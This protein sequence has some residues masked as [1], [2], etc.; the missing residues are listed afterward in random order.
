MALANKTVNYTPFNKTSWGFN[1][2]DLSGTHSGLT[3]VKVV[4]TV[5]S[6]TNQWDNTGHISTPTSGS[7]VASYNKDKFEWSCSGPLAD[8]DAVLVALDLFPADF[9]AIRSWTNL[10]IKPNETDGDF[11]Y[12]GGYN[13][14][15]EQDAPIP[16]TIFDLK[17]YD[18]DNLSAGVVTGG[19]YEITFDAIHPTFG[20]QRPYWSTEPS[21]EDASS[22][23]FSLSTGG[24]LDLGEISQLN[25][26]TNVSDDDPLTLTCEFRSFGV[27]SPPYSGG[28]YGTLTTTSDGTTNKIFIGNKK[29]GAEDTTNR[30]NFTGTRAEVQ[31]YLDNV[32]Y[33]RGVGATPSFTP[34]TF[35]PNYDAFDM[36]FKLSNGVVA[37]EYTKHIH[38]SDAVIGATTI[39]GLSYTEDTVAD[40]D[41]NVATSD[42]S[43][44]VTTYTATITLDTVGIGGVDTFGTSSSFNAS[45]YGNDFTEDFNTSTG[46]LTI[47]HT[48]TSGDTILLLALRNLEFTPDAD[49]NSSFNM[50]FQLIY[51]GLVNGSTYTSTQ[52]TVAVS[53]TPV[54][55]ID[56]PTTSHTFA[57]DTRYNFDSGGAG[58]YPQISHPV[59]ENFTVTFTHAA[60]TGSAPIWRGGSVPST[61]SNTSTTFTMSGT[62]NEVN[63]GFQNLYYSPATDSTTGET[64]TFTVDRTSGDLTHETQST[65]SFVMTATEVA[66][67]T[68]SQ[69]TIDWEKDN[70]IL[71][72]SGL[73]ILDGSTDAGLPGAGA[74]YTVECA[75]WYGISEYT[76]GT[77]NTNTIGSLTISGNGQGDTNKLI[78]TGTKLDINAALA[79]MKFIP[80]CGTT[81]GPSIF[82][83]LIRNSSPVVVFTDQSQSEKTVFNTASNDNYTYS[84]GGYSTWTEDTPKDFDCGVRITDGKGVNSGCAI[85]GT[86]YTATIQAYYWD[87][88]TDQD[89]TTA[90]WSTTSSGSASVTGNGKSGTPLV[91][92]GTRLDVNTALQNLR[93]T[94]DLD[95][96]D[97]PSGDDRF[98]IYVDLLRNDDSLA[99][100]DG[101][102][103][104]VFAGFEGGTEN[105]VLNYVSSV[106]GMAYTEDTTTSI[107]SG[108]NVGITDIAADN[109]PVTYEVT[110]K[111]SEDGS[112]SSA[113]PGVW[114]GTSSH[115]ITLTTDTKTN[116]NTAIQALQFTPSA[117]YN[118]DVH[119][120]YTQ[121]RYLSGVLNT[122]QADNIDLG[123][124]TGTAAAEFIYGTANSNIQY[125]V[126]D[127]HLIGVDTTDTEANILNGTANTTLTPARIS[128]NKGLTYDRPITVTD[129][130]EDG[131]ASEYK[132]VFS[133]GT[134]LAISGVSL[135]TTDTGW[136][137]KADLHT[138]LDNGIYTTGIND[139]MSSGHAHDQTN[140][141]NFTLHRRTYTGTESQIANGQLTYKF[142]TGIKM[143]KYNDQF[144]TYTRMD[145][146]ADGGS[147]TLSIYY[148]GGWRQQGLRFGQFNMQ[149][150]FTGGDTIGHPDIR[151]RLSNTEYTPN[152]W[153]SETTIVTSVF[154]VWTTSTNPTV[155]DDFAF[156]TISGHTPYLLRM[157]DNLLFSPNNFS[158]TASSSKIAVKAWTSW[159]ALLDSGKPLQ[160][161]T[162]YE[163]LL[164][165]V[166]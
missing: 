89:L 69:A 98:Y 125:Y 9:P 162:A 93:M 166:P 132:I 142:Q 107:F 90:T 158:N 22:A 81:T 135:N 56:N 35:V 49:F 48:S 109:Y 94:P 73:A 50:T 163:I 123:T 82:Y 153:D 6:G 46:V 138:L 10:E 44:D 62:R 144:N 31:A 64:I 97:A 112:T 165:Y 26:T 110:L 121:K 13:E 41:L 108:K 32:R 16:D 21:N 76:D 86:D 120:L 127:S 155:Y 106:T 156:T 114:T 131:G 150:D 23:D 68:I 45:Q 102:S 161:S 95:W 58:T 140:T 96:T 117:E 42:V 39:T 119:I 20:K 40:F 154:R 19:A 14:E 71:F 53:G 74:T 72:D 54:A 88:S 99:I 47:S 148:S 136:Q 65:G 133:G 67:Y 111:L 75:M 33:Y 61:I 36:Y 1:S 55:E 113:L 157:S 59:N 104:S 160:S 5:K 80:D 118:T 51:T 151:V 38:F 146:T 34:P 17:V 3:N 159:G 129:T 24:L 115:E 60:S 164:D 137:T 92:D 145:N 29:P 79:D 141:V 18:A 130:Y 83:K 28:V 37:S 4:I 85:F 149:D 105:E 152:I 78:M 84:F 134:L 12:Y 143:F 91:I 30:I 57:E 126:P 25:P 77:L 27:I 122:T 43:S 66:E 87:G 124:V 52:Q 8:V 11:P 15:P 128:L 70:T 101:S 147:V 7:A 103:S 139:T 63:T 100:L 2:T 116:V